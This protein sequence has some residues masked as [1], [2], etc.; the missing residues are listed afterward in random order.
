MHFKSDELLFLKIYFEALSEADFLS[1]LFKIQH[2]RVSVQGNCIKVLWKSRA[3]GLLLLD[4][5]L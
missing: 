2:G 4:D 3:E 5:V 1:I